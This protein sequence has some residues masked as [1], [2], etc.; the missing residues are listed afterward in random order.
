MILRR[1]N[2]LLL[3]SVPIIT[4]SVG[5]SIHNNLLLFERYFN[6]LQLKE[7]SPVSKRLFSL[8]QLKELTP[9]S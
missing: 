9:A 5:L 1:N 8:C 6:I 2:G 4:M 3:F 7:Y